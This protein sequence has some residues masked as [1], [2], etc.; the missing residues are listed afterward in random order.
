MNL[1]RNLYAKLAQNQKHSESQ[2]LKRNLYPKLA[3][4][5]SQS[6]NQ[7][8]NL[9]QRTKQSSSNWTVTKIA[10]VKIVHLRKRSFSIKATE[11]RPNL[12]SFRNI[13]S[14][15]A[16]LKALIGEYQPTNS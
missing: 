14:M 16:E 8:Q 3:L 6:Q 7:S 5:K 4:S 2:N 1:I 11:H 9:N 15:M 10:V 13:T 12:T